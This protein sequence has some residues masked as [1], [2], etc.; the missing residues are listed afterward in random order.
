M[1]ESKRGLLGCILFL[2]LITFTSCGDIIAKQE[3]API[4]LADRKID[5]M[6][7]V[8]IK[9]DIEDKFEVDGRVYSSKIQKLSFKKAGKLLYY[10]V[11]VGKEVKKGEL[12]A[13]ID[14]SE[15]EHKI[16]IS[17][18]KVEQEEIKLVLAKRT[19]DQHKIKE[20]EIALKIANME[21]KKLNQYLDNS[22]L[23]A[24]VDG[25][26]S[27]VS[28]KDIGSIVNPNITMISIMDTNELGVKFNLN[29]TQ[30]E[31][32]KVGDSIEIVIDDN[33][34]KTEIVNIKKN[35]VIAEMP[36]ELEGRLK[37]A[38]KIKVKKSLKTIKDA[39]LVPKIAI[40]KDS[41]G[42]SKVQVLED[43]KIITKSVKLGV[44][45][46][47][48]FQILEGVKEGQEIIVK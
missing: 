19:G 25:I 11:Y 17:K 45:L 31:Q 28:K 32:I 7:E 12:L 34:Y 13:A 15:I 3:K 26:I 30:L 16:K 27:S 20:A 1:K 35:Q 5:F 24:E 36:K 38:Y 14:I 21:L 46:D 9:K 47:D 18:L 33:D 4:L 42:A 10:D 48:Y 37:I 39:I 29:K 6:T 44:E 2:I 41:T 23:V 8:A 40:Y 22:T 43:E